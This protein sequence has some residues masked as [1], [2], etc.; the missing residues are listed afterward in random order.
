MSSFVIVGGGLAGGKAAESARAEGF[1]GSIV[2]VAAEGVR[3]YE[4]PP[5]SKSVLKGED[6]PSVAFVHEEGW[7]AEHDV[8]LR[9]N[10]TASELDL[11][12]GRIR[13]ADGSDIAFDHVL[14]ATGAEPKTLPLPGAGLEGVRLLRSMDDS[15]RLREALQSAG[16]L[17]MVGASWIGC[18]VAAAARH[19]GV[20]VVMIDPVA[21]PLST[22]LGDELGRVFRD[23]HAEHGV[24]LQ[25]STEVEGFEEASG[26]LV[27]VRA[28]GER[29]ECD[30]AVIGVGVAPRIELARAAG[31]E[32]DNGIVVDARLRSSDERVLAAG[33]VARVPFPG[34]GPLRVEHWASALEQ[35]SLAGRSLVRPDATWEHIPFFFS[36]QY[37]LGM[38]YRGMGSSDDQ[39]V[40]RGDPASRELLAFWLREGRVKAAANLNV[41]DYGDELEKLVREQPQ[42]D[43][44]ALAD[45]DTP[46]AELART[47][48]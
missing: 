32:L 40:L 18:E 26:R 10:T 15:I 35:G 6:E 37:D 5:L 16:R 44:R 27:A 7:Y 34:F 29:F 4:R 14:L 13:L 8:E 3:P 2:I 38:E 28:G 22:I 12:E 43:P 39:V 30:L 36:D 1:D 45:P 17:V 48:A 42:V 19:H 21:L 31:L 47:T 23:L 9:L 25:L 46:L 20:E 33:D 11:R 41:W 24:E